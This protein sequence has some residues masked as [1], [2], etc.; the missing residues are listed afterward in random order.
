M[1]NKY[2]ATLICITILALAPACCKKSCSKKSPSEKRQKE[3]VNT[4]IELDNSVFE[5]ETEE[6]NDT[7]NVVKF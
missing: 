5:V 3:N 6:D 2:I 1:N 7:N 4:M